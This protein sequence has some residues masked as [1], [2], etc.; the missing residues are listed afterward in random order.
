MLWIGK[1]HILLVSSLQVCLGMALL[2]RTWFL[3]KH[4]HILGYCSNL[5][6]LL[7]LPHT[8]TF[9]EIKKCSIYLFEGIS[10]AFILMTRWCIILKLL[11]SS[12]FFKES[13]S[14]A[15]V[16]TQYILCSYECLNGDSTIQVH[17]IV[18]SSLCK[19]KPVGTTNIY[20]SLEEKPEGPVHFHKNLSVSKTQRGF[21]VRHRNNGEFTVKKNMKTFLFCCGKQTIYFCLSPSAHGQAPD[22]NTHG[23]SS[24]SY[25][26]CWCSETCDS[27]SQHAAQLH[28]S[29]RSMGLQNGPSFREQ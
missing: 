13:N 29:I 21:F 22:E 17:F 16:N 1:R 26:K 24:S 11:P 19:V 15:F 9:A 5:P 27:T 12:K 2:V 23:P 10:C 7:V 18:F 4:A 28:A 8:T 20:N 3:N 6:W 14:S 25:R